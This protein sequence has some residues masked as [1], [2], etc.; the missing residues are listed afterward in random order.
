M[1]CSRT[2]RRLWFSEAHT[3]SLDQVMF[4]S[5]RKPKPA[6]RTVGLL[7]CHGPKTP[8]TSTTF[9]PSSAHEDLSLNMQEGLRKHSGRSLPEGQPKEDFKTSGS[10]LELPSDW[11]MSVSRP[12][13]NKK[14]GQE[15]LQPFIAI[16]VL[17]KPV[18][19]FPGTALH[20]KLG[21]EGTPGQESFLFTRDFAT[22][23]PLG[24]LWSF[25]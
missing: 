8:R 1:Y 18:E 22:S 5:R 3:G 21:D 10:L 20:F 4:W 24:L 11:P 15:I 14:F 13:C 25:G 2:R 16:R 6:P 23:F 9:N 17:E 7:L 19:L 12:S